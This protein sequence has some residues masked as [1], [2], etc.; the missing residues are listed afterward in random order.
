MLK[1]QSTV[2]PQV[3]LW[4]GLLCVG[5]RGEGAA[6]VGKV[7]WLNQLMCLCVRLYSGKK[8]RKEFGVLIGINGKMNTK[9]RNLFTSNEEK[10]QSYEK[11]E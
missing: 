4:S 10:K 2:V 7:V 1:L 3:M 8:N 6:P 11:S 5:S 9:D